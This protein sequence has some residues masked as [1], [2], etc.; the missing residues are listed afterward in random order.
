MS[1]KTKCAICAL[2]LFSYAAQR[3]KTMAS[4]SVGRAQPAV[5]RLC[6]A[7]GY[8]RCCRPFLSADQGCQEI[9]RKFSVY[10]VLGS[11]K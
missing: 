9:I 11:D 4:G 1:A 8:S 10:V 5:C 6:A 3:I 2:A 7:I